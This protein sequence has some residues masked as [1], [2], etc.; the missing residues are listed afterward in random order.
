MRPYSLVY[1]H[2]VYFYLW[3]LCVPG[4]YTVSLGN[5]RVHNKVVVH[6]VLVAVTG[7][8]CDCNTFG[9]GWICKGILATMVDMYEATQSDSHYVPMAAAFFVTIISKSRWF[10][11]RGGHVL[12]QLAAI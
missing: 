3:L 11:T 2:I 7:C 1:W 9:E 12:P 8:N 10:G 4:S 5:K 6:K